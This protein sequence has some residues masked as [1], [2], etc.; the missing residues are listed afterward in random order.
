MGHLSLAETSLPKVRTLTQL[1]SADVQVTCLSRTR[2]KTDSKLAR[3]AD[4]VCKTRD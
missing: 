1:I 4:R 2:V 3:T